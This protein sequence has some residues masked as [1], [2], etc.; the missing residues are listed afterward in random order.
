MKKI[1]TFIIGILFI[2]VPAVAADYL[3]VGG[4]YSNTLARGMTSHA[5]GGNISILGDYGGV[6]RI[7][8]SVG[9]VG[10]VSSNRDLN[11]GFSMKMQ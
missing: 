6:K 3:Y 9:F 7:Y 2:A 10:D 5:I 1:I 8:T 11:Q 4:N